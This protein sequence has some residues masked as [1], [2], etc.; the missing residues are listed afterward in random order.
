MQQKEKEEHRFI[1]YEI[2]SLIRF[3]LKVIKN[4]NGGSMNSFTMELKHSFIQR[5][6]YQN[7]ISILVAFWLFTSSLTAQH[8]PSD[9]RSDPNFRAKNQLES[10]NVRTTLFNY[11]LTGREGAV[12]ITEQ[13]PYEWYKNTGQVYLALTGPCI[14]AEVVDENGDTIHIVDV[15]HYRNSPQGEPWTFEPIP[16]Y[17]NE[18]IFK[19][20]SSDDPSTWP[21]FWPDRM[22]DTTDPGWAGSWDG[23]FGK[24]VLIDGQELYFKFTDD[25]YDK[26]SYYPDTTDLTR[27]GLGLIISGRAIAFNEDFLKD[28]V[29]YSYKIKNDGTK[30]LNKLGLSLW[31]ADFVGGE[32]SENMIGYDLSKN[33]IWSFNKDNRS[34]D[35]AFYDEPV[36]A[37]SLS[38]LKYPES[39]LTFNNIQYLPSN[40][41][42]P[43]EPD[44]FL[45]DMF[46]TPGYFVDTSSIGEG[47]YIAYATINY[48][49]LQPG[50]TKEI[51]F[52]VSL[53]NGPSKDPFHTIRR[54]RITGQ[55]YAAIAALQADFI[56]DTYSVDIVS[57]S[58]GQT[59]ESNVNISWTAN[60]ASNRIADYI[61][62]SSD[63]G[64]S[65][66]FL[67]V[68]SSASGNYNWNTENYP[69]GIMFKIRIISVSENG[70]AV[71]VSDGIFKINKSNVNALPQVYITSPLPNSVISGDY[72]I[73]LISGDAD[74]EP[75]QVDMFF[76]IGKYY[77]WE[78]LADNVQ[79][80]YYEFDSRQLPNTD[81]FYL[82]AIVTSNSDSGFYR[83]KHIIVNNIRTIYPDSTLLLYD[84]TPATGIF[85]V[86]VVNPSGLTGDDY[87]T[88]FEQLNNILVYD[89]V[90]LTTGQKLVDDATEINGNFE[91]PYFDGLRLFIDNEPLQEI[92]SLSGWNN[93]GIF[94]V[95]FSPHF[96]HP[97]WN[98]PKRS[99][100]R[101]EIEELGIDT[102]MFWI[103]Y[104][105]TLP[106]V[107]VNFKVYN[108]SE[109][110]YVDF[111]FYELDFTEGSGHFTRTSNGMPDY[112]FL[113]ET[114]QPDTLSNIISLDDCDSCSNPQTG[115]IYLHYITKPFYAG[116]S[117]LF[118][119]QNITTVL[120]EHSQPVEFN[121]EQNYPNPFN[122]TTKIK[123]QLPTKAYVQ[124]EVYDILGRRISTLINKEMNAGTYESEFEGRRFASG[125]YIYR[126]Q[127]GSFVSSK[128]MILLK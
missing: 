66:S 22:S 7:I 65:W 76:K 80:N 18:T 75:V 121:L 56:F 87:V 53:A 47:D 112:I 108:L 51:L 116:D 71:G 34:P 38:I 23:Y 78:L 1:F 54:N 63:N 126:I 44:E 46:F 50:E 52:A 15:F 96:L 120:D 2:N 68:D 98:P 36:G 113:L 105:N 92:D 45:W 24:N 32:G 12:P 48:F 26:Y 114:S 17:F 43:E 31:W 33:F 123:F 91:G 101:I 119:T 29:F 77:S 89:V 73:S 40:I 57:P 14:G 60:G 37:V 103:Y 128:K 6:S 58:N 104:G 111:A 117:I 64:D 124:L 93:E 70:S 39:G 3:Y 9:E 81:D 86:R 59:F 5:R 83:V 69:D 95:Y 28:I 97:Q 100:Y 82:K 125:V 118:S 79:N 122:P 109:G 42:P 49:S 25:L 72:T 8:I 88:V 35:P 55:Y 4:K 41:W 107:P 99:D 21:A 84:N 61:Y 110:R 74:N 67:A 102:S 85:E 30:P 106:A 11:G 115:D 16:G 94:P 62:Y 127:A 10:N 13:T 90:N 20:A 19:I 27:K